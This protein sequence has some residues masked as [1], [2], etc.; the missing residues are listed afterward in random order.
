NDPDR[1]EHRSRIDYIMHF[2]PPPK[3]PD[4]KLTVRDASS[5]PFDDATCD[6][7]YLSDHKAIEATIEITRHPNLRASSPRPHN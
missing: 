4:T 6:T 1:W 7:R 2:G 5:H 3:S